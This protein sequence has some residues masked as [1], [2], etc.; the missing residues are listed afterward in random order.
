MRGHG[1]DHDDSFFRRRGILAEVVVGELGRV[2]YAD[3]VHVESEEGGF[4]RLSIRIIDVSK[5]FSRFWRF[6]D[7]SVTIIFSVSINVLIGRGGNVREDNVDYSVRVLGRLEQIHLLLPAR[8]IA[9][10]GRSLPV[11]FQ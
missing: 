9:R 5:P 2:C 6:G 11:A 7:T 8:H 3:E 1:S 10:D 4:L